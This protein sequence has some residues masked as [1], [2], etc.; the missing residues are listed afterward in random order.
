MLSIAVARRV[1]LAWL[2]IFPSLRGPPHLRVYACLT[3]GRATVGFASVSIC[4]SGSDDQ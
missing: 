2:P 1:A 4:L 3:Q